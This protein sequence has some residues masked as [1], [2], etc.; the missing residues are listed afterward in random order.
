[1]AS[2]IEEL[3][4]DVIN[5]EHGCE[6]EDIEASVKNFVDDQEIKDLLSKISDSLTKLN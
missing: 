5:Q 3:V 2:L 1:L 6:N 4:A